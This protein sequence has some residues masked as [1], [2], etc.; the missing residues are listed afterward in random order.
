MAENNKLGK[1]I[2]EA[3]HQLKLS[4]NAA[5]GNTDLNGL[6]ARILGFVE[7]NDYLG[8]DVYQKDIEA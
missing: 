5:F 7:Y 6:Q 3:S 4:L 2:I 8:K 1:Y